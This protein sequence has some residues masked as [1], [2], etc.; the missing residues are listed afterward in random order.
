M[1]PDKVETVRNWKTPVNLTDVQAFIGFVNFYRRF[2]KD[3]SKTI[4]PLVSLTKKAERFDWNSKRQDAFERLKSAF[5]SA[6]VLAAFNWEKCHRT[7]WSDY[8][9]RLPYQEAHD[10]LGKEG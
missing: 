4:S 8:D 10:R 5:T 6:P 7:T 9:T 3:F 1:D 2:I